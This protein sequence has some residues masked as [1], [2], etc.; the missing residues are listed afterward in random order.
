MR[1]GTGTRTSEDHDFREFLDEDQDGTRK[2]E[3]VNFKKFPKGPK[4]G[5]A[6]PVP[7]STALIGNFIGV[8]F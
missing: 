4:T 1:S 6:S 2:S 3:D 7:N 5:T 8:E